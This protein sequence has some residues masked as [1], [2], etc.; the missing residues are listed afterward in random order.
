MNS[1]QVK[2]KFKQLSGEIKRKWGQVTDDDLTDARAAG[3]T[4]RQN[5]GAFGRS[6]RGHR[7]VAEIAGNESVAE[8]PVAKIR[9]VIL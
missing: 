2:G 1:D 8:N 4:G 3:K 6:A 9:E 7:E 5:P